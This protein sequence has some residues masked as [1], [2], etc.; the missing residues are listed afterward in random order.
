LVIIIYLTDLTESSQYETSAGIS[1]VVTKPKN[2]DQ[3]HAIVIA[4]MMRSD[5]RASNATITPS[6]KS[7]S[8]TALQL[9]PCLIVRP[10][11]VFS[12]AQL[13]GPS[14]R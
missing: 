13:A 2:H 8:V 1:S 11:E 3:A 9:L 12:L 10:W 7:D 5:T 4:A 6:T 14:D